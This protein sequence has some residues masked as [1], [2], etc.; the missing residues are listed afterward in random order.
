MAGSYRESGSIGYYTSSNFSMFAYILTLDQINQPYY[1][2]ITYPDDAF[3]DFCIAVR[4]DDHQFPQGFIVYPATS[5]VDAGGEFALTYRMLTTS[6]VHWAHQTDPRII[7]YVAES[8]G[9]VN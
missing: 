4:E 5:G 3:R 9:K 8:P 7:L 1:I 6:I 2:E